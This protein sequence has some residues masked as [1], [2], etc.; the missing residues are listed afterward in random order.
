MPYKSGNTW[1]GYTWKSIT[2]GQLPPLVNGCVPFSPSS[3][4][5]LTAA[6]VD[7]TLDIYDLTRSDVFCA[8]IVGTN[9]IAGNAFENCTELTTITF[10]AGLTE[11][12]NNAFQ[13]CVNLTSKTNTGGI[14]TIGS[15]AFRNTKIEK[16]NFP[17]VK[18]IGSGAFANNGFLKSATLPEVK[19]IANEPIFW[20]CP[21]FESLTLG[22]TPP[23]ITGGGELF[24][25]DSDAEASKAENV[26]LHVPENM[27]S[28][29]EATTFFAEAGFLAIV[30]KNTLRINTII[31]K[32]GTL[33]INAKG[34]DPA[35]IVI[36]GE[37]GEEAIHIQ[38]E[39][40]IEMQTTPPK[41]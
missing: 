11:I 34:G 36:K 13:G 10:S 14:Q 40:Q 32:K 38:H 35:P 19:I 9:T 24:G 5:I 33:T 23:E 8:L 29:Y 18:N 17:N 6:D 1:N 37:E 41:E 3:G 30:Q 39:E 31:L 2:G 4:G 15:N 25:G 27:K 20:N 21:S 26:T 16:A 7:T 28:V 22:E 12:A